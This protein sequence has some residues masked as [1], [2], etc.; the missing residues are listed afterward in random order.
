MGAMSIPPLEY[1][2]RATW[3]DVPPSIQK[4]VQEY[5]AMNV[6]IATA[7]STIK[8]ENNDEFETNKDS[9][10]KNSSSSSICMCCNHEQCTNIIQKEEQEGVSESV[11]K[12]P[13]FHSDNK[14]KKI[15]ESSSSSSSTSSDATSQPSVVN[16]GGFFIQSL[17]GLNHLL[18]AV[19]PLFV[20]CTLEDI[21]IHMF[22]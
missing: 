14:T 9:C 5:C 18:L 7:T 10:C 8:H 17:H 19:A 22:L 20:S 1:D 15:Y 6:A 4:E 3:I 11:H 21:G 2:T 13:K 16:Q 12:R